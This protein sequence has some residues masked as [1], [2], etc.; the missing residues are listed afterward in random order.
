MT[1]NQKNKLMEN[2]LKHEGLRSLPRF[3]RLLKYPLRTFPYYLLAALSHLKSFKLTFKTLWGKPMTC[4]LP[5]G[6]TF[7]YYGYCE[8]NL[9]NFFLRF[10]TPGIKVI[11]AGAHVGFYTMLLSELVGEAGQVHSFEPTPWTFNLLSENTRSLKNVRINHAALADKAGE[12]TFAD[13][14]PGY[15][16][17]NSAHQAGA[18]ALQETSN[19]TQAPA[20][21]LDNYCHP[22]GIKP[23][24]IKIDTEGFEFEVLTGGRELFNGN[25]KPL[26]TIEVAGGE[27]WQEN[28]ERSFAFLKTAGYLPYE[29]KVDGRLSPHTLKA[30]YEYD[31]LLFIPQERLSEI[32]TLLV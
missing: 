32:T 13:Y 30:S 14:G 23:D 10:V 26:V 21:T 5:E 22:R 28:R 9:T 29:I 6:N 8:A 15:G 25:E 11:D 3:T 2:I 27:A 19:K 1:D 24:L 16:A 7:Y 4:Y 31:N 18:P 12:L 20:L 17:Y